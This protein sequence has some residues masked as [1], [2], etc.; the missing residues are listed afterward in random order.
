MPLDNGR[1]NVAGKYLSFRDGD[2]FASGDV[3]NMAQ[4]FAGLPE[5]Y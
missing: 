3:K 2:E 1:L 4:G 5:I